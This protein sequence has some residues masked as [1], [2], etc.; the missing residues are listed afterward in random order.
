MQAMKPGEVMEVSASDPGFA[1]DI[2]AWCRRTG[3]TLLSNEKQGDDYVALVRKGGTPVPAGK[4][5]PEG[6]T[7]VVFSGDMDKALASFIIA[8]GAAAMGRPVTMFFTFWGLTVLRRPEKVKVKKNLVE[9]MFGFMLPRGSG[10]LKLSHMNMAGMGT[11]MMKVIMKQ[12]NVDSLEMLISK[13]MKA[14]VKLVACT[15]SMDIMGIHAE[16]LIDGVELGGVGAYLG[17]AEESNVNLFI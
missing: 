3:N 17:D 11:G 10:K 12:K 15:M 2:G 14:G 6:K 7:I 4:D 5:T 13:A 8:N 16:E 9:K 1:R